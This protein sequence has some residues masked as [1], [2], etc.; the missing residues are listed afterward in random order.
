MQNNKR[1]EAGEDPNGC[2]LSGFDCVLIEVRCIK[3]NVIET[4]TD[5]L[6]DRQDTDG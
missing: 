3:R 5:I 2:D 4:D 1:G 6:T